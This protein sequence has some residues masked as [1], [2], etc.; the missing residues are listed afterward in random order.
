MKNILLQIVFVLI[1]VI[2]NAQ[3]I[4]KAEI[5]EDIEGLCDKDNVYALLPFAGQVEASCGLSD[6]DIQNKLNEEVQFLKDNPK[7]KGKGMV[8]IIVNCKGEV[9]SCKMDNKTKDPELD[10]QILDVF[11]KLVNWK[12]GTLDGKAVDSVLLFSFEIKK[13]K[14][15]L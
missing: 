11:K 13:G 1:S 15:V 2:G 14:F 6:L 10:K 5:K 12:A 8:Q 3:F 4:A 9:V 7:F